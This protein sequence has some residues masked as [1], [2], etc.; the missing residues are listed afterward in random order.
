MA[1][2]INPTISTV[3]NQK[4]TKPS[5]FSVFIKWCIDQEKNRFGWLALALAVN[6]CVLTPITMFAIILSSNSILLWVV[7]I[8]AFQLSL[9]TNLAAMPTK[10]T[11]PA[12]LLNAVIDLVVIISCAATG[13]NIAGTYI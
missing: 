4:V 13:F 3:L 9:V 7:T 1:T 6:G 11:I 12:F 2:I 10:Y 8:A 5:L